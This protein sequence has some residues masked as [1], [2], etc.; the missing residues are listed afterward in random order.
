[1]SASITIDASGLEQMARA[2]NA[3]SEGVRTNRALL[4]VGAIVTS[5]TRHRIDSEKR[6]PWG[7]SW[8]RWSPEYAK[9]RHANQS[10]LMSS[11]LLRDSI[12]HQITRS[13][14]IV[15][16]NRFYAKWHQ[17]G[18]SKMPE[19]A[20]LG[21]GPDDAEEIEQTVIRNIRKLMRS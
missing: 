4:G 1:M 20:F 14:V 18:T 17:E 19:R 15:G 2:L 12:T 13:G 16:S 5:Q 6:D 10:L 7:K 3:I 9:T 8:P 11:G 21:I